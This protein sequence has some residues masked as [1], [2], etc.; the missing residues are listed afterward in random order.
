MHLAERT[1]VDRKVLRDREYLPPVDHAAAGDHAVAKGT[2]AV[3]AEVGG[4]H[5]HVR[6]LFDEGVLVEQQIE[7]LAG[8]QLALGVLGVDTRLP[9]RLEHLLPRLAA[10]LERVTHQVAPA[11]SRPSPDTDIQI[12]IP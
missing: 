9:A 5:R 8:G 12:D 3:E 4:A 6:L 2:A 7:A 10:P 1:A 11:G